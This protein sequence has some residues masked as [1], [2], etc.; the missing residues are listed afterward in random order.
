[1]VIPNSEPGGR[2]AQPT[3]QPKLNNDLWFWSLEN[4]ISFTDLQE[5]VKD[6]LFYGKTYI[7]EQNRHEA[8]VANLLLLGAGECG[9]TTMM[10]QLILPQRPSG[11]DTYYSPEAMEWEV[12]S[13]LRRVLQRHGPDPLER[14]PPDAFSVY[15]FHAIV[16]TFRP[17]MDTIRRIRQSARISDEK[18][19]YYLDLLDNLCSRP[20]SP[21]TPSAQDI[22]QCYVTTT[23][24]QKETVILADKVYC[25][26]D[27]GGQR[28]ERKKWIH[29]FS[30]AS[31]VIFVASLSEYDQ[32]L[33]EEDSVVLLLNKKDVL[34][35]KIEISPINKYFPDYVGGTDVDAACEYFKDRFKAG[36]R[37]RFGV[38]V[39]FLSSVNEDEVRGTSLFHT[40][41]TTQTHVQA[42]RCISSDTS[43]I[44]AAKT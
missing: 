39:Y 32:V 18:T 35:R 21:Y 7:L 40:Q 6:A 24:I 29:G 19:D 42:Y 14:K 37:R 44:H 30:N 11:L 17:Y 34:E 10:K 36:M 26:H 3:Q 16:D 25:I 13:S 2:P 31:L 43:N 23:G 9:K 12:R 28:S 4:N 27:F 5:A 41:L 38:P 33:A 20:L 1:M 22:I 15:G 8:A